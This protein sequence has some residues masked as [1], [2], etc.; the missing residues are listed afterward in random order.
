MQ[1][2][3]VRPAASEFI[4]ILCYLCI[5]DAE[6]ISKICWRLVF[7]LTLQMS[8]AIQRKAKLLMPIF[9]YMSLL[10]LVAQA[11]AVIVMFSQNFM[12][13][14]MW[15]LL[16]CIAILAVMFCYTIMRG[17]PH[18]R[19]LKQNQLK[20]SWSWSRFQEL[21]FKLKMKRHRCQSNFIWFDT[22]RLC[23]IN[24]NPVTSNRILAILNIYESWN[25]AL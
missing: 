21:F 22:I 3:W 16:C 7:I 19:L 18:A 14:G 9:L 10:V 8:A 11:A 23:L 24:R 17:N 4:W 2:I 15:F 6:L 13:I 12:P 20:L 25:C 5:T 1:N